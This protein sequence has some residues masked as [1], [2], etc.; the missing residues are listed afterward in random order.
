[1]KKKLADYSE[2]G[3][4]KWKTFKVEFNHDMSELGKAFS[5]LT[6]NNVN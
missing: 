5:D 2:D 4:E 3:N 1:L 6:V